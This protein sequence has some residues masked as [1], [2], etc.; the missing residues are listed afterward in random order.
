MSKRTNAPVL[1]ILFALPVAWQPVPAHAQQDA[2]RA[3]ANRQ[4]TRQI[5][6]SITR[7][8]TQEILPTAGGAEPE[9]VASG[10]VSPS[11]TN[12]DFTDLDGDIEAYQVVGGADKRLGSFYTGAS[13]GY[14]FLD[15][16][17]DPDVSGLADEDVFG[18]HNPSFSPYAAYMINDNFFVT[19]IAGYSRLEVD[20]GPAA[21]LDADSLFTDLSVTGLLPLN[22]WIVVGQ[23]GHRFV[24]TIVEE[25]GSADDDAFQN[26]LYLAGEVGYRIERWLPYFRVSYEHLI[27]EEGDDGEVVFV[28]VGSTYDFSDVFSAGLAYKTELNQLD[29]FNYNQAALDIRFRF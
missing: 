29:N 21:E 12:I 2:Q 15:L 22:Q 20:Q 28:G 16:D 23:F 26:T 19:G 24:Y 6:Q 13:V 14:T 4:A 27:P 3:E 25:V 1:G 9:E 5:T 17:V 18:A 8:I 7:R 10:W 11:Y